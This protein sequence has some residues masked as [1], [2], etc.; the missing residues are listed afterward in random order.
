[1]KSVYTTPFQ[2][3][4]LKDFLFLYFRK[5]LS[6]FSVELAQTILSR[7]EI[8]ERD[9]NP[10]AFN[11]DRIASR[12]KI[13]V[14]TIQRKL[15]KDNITFSKIKDCVRFFFCLTWAIK[16]KYLNIFQLSQKL[17]YK[18]RA[19]LTHAFKRWTGESP[20]IFLMDFRKKPIS[21]IHIVS[22]Y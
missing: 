3:N 16:T 18:D 9:A 12:M 17:G 11:L 1:M 5:T 8:N 22:Q 19:C 10:T 7:I 2:I 14:R 15:S 4:S 20:L 6:E 21:M 13:S